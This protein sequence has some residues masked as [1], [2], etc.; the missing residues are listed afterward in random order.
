MSSNQNSLFNDLR[1]SQHSDKNE[2]VQLVEAAAVGVA[3][4]LAL[5]AI[6]LYLKSKENKN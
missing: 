6:A 5:G 4:V 2:N 1:A 3:F